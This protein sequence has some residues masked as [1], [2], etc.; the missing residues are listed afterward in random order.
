MPPTQK[1]DGQDVMDTAIQ[2]LQIPEL[3]ENLLNPISEESPAGAPA[4]TDEE[5]FKLEME[6]GKP[7]PDYKTAIDLATALLQNKSKDLRVASWLC[8]AWYRSEKIA[9]LRNGIILL[10][11]LLN[12][13]KDHLYPENPV[14]RVKAIQFLNSSRFIKILEKETLGKEDAQA[15]LDAEMI[16]NQLVAASREQ[17][18]DNP[19]DFKTLSKIIASHTESA[20]KWIKEEPSGPG[21]KEAKAEEKP[22]AKKEDIRTPS[23]EE[24]AKPEQPKAEKAAPREAPAVVPESRLS[25]DSEAKSAIKKALSFYFK[26]EEGD[27]RKYATYLY[28]ISRTLI[29]SS[30]LLPP[31]TD[32]STELN[33]P[34]AEIKATLDNWVTNQEWQKLVSAI[35]VNLLNE[36]NTFKYWLTAQ[37]YV[38]EALESIGGPA[39]KAAAEVKFQLAKLIHRLP[40]IE[41]LK[42]NNDMPFADE[43]TLEWIDENVKSILQGGQGREKILPPIL[44]ED[45]EPI[46]KEYEEACAELPDKFESHMEKMQKGIASDTRR[47]GRFLRTLNL[48]NLCIQA[49]EYELAKV[50]LANL[51]D[52]IDAYQLAEWEPAL[53]VSVWQSTYLVNLKLLDKEKDEDKLN[54]LTKQQDELFTKIGNYDGLLAL[55]LAKRN[56]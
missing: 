21:E 32:S 43:Q 46:N 45:Y 34:D 17:F 31:H 40:R 19:P 24:A 15:I 55:G 28:G 29:W 8:F 30:L 13:F 2:E 38:T 48:A 26:L 3:V 22:P 35:E 25:S 54:I 44:G 14:H 42:F 9:G 56:T 49:K 47:K 39:A 12:E 52:K 27:E 18:P 37:R 53:C 41:Q 10:L 51:L 16:F 5:Y 1:G 6:M 36:E 7:S 33:P 4:V 50:H 20:R 23:K 11:N